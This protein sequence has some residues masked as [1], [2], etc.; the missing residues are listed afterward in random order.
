M[1]IVCVSKTHNV[2]HSGLAWKALDGVKTRIQSQ[3]K[4]FLVDS[5]PVFWSNII[6][7]EL[8]AREAQ[9]KRI[10]SLTEKL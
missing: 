7:V 3:S 6:I 8:Y 5:G 10:V 4:R 2:C 1:D 9:F